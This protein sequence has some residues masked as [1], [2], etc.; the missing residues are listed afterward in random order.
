MSEAELPEG[1]QLTRSKLM[2]PID[3]PSNSAL[4]FPLGRLD[5]DGASISV[6]QVEI[7]GRHRTLAS[8]RA[9]RSYYVVSG[10]VHFTLDGGEPLLLGANDL[11]VIPRG[12]RYSLEGRATYLVINSPA[13]EP[14]DDVY[15]E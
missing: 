14:D 4:V 13:F 11:L 9:P 2:T 6:T 10:S 12:C 1:A 5:R 3:E 8:R 15:F 7:D